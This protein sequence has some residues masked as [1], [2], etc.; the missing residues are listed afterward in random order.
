MRLALTVVSPMARHRADVVIDADPA[1][2]VGELAAE[3]DRLAPGGF[4]G[5][6][7]P[8][9]PGSAQVLQFP[10]PRAH[11]S[12]AMAGP[13]VGR[14]Q[15][16]QAVPLFVDFQRVPPQLSLAQSPIRDGAVISL[17]SPE[18]CLRPEPTG[19]VEIKIAGG[20]AAGVVHRL[21]LGEAYIGSANNATI[22]IADQSVP[23]LALRVLIDR[24]GDTQVA[25]FDG[26]QATIDREPITGP[27]PWPQGSRSRSATR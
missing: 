22:V 6:Q 21:S 17:G 16:A 10:G 20:P 26:V 23:P 12:L 27:M 18:G 15:Q 25:P 11:G 24:R 14:G 1:T 8:T 13:V 9:G 7:P 3:L 19:L 4:T 2:P 5:Q